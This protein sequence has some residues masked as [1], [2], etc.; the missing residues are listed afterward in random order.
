[1]RAVSDF[2]GE[3]EEK[4]PDELAGRSSA[5]GFDG[6]PLAQDREYRIQVS[7]AEHRKSN[8]GK[9]QF[10]VTFEVI[11][12]PGDEFVGRK[13]S[14]YFSIDKDA[15][16]A[17]RQSFARFLGAS[18]LNVA[19]LDQSSNE[20]F[21]AE[22]E[23]LTFICAT[24]T[25]GTEDDRTGV[26]YLNQDRGQDPRPSIAPPKSKTGAKPLK[27]DIMVN[28]NKGPAEPGPAAVAT[29]SETEEAPPASPPVTLPGSGVRA[30]VNLPPGLSK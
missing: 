13:F 3:A 9:W 21:I 1:M 29:D 18:G 26:R 4:F 27:A 7:R 6:P 5:G 2:L 10:A 17:A 28:K 30:P 20:A 24:R 14:E 8:S 16:E 11:N 19:E 22:F 12:D 25:W 15:H 23:G